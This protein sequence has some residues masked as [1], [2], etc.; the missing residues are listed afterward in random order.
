MRNALVLASELGGAAT[1]LPSIWVGLDRWWAPHD[2]RLP[3]SRI[4]LPFAAP[5]DLVLDLEM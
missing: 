5:A 1:V 4:D 3:N 2:G